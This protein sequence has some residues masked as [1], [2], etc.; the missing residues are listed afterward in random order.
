MALKLQHIKLP[1]S[2]LAQ[3]FILDH[4]QYKSLLDHLQE[5]HED[6]FEDQDIMLENRNVGSSWLHA[7]DGT[8]EINFIGHSAPGSQPL[9]DAYQ[10]ALS[11]SRAVA[12]K[13]KFRALK[14]IKSYAFDIQPDK[15]MIPKDAGV[16]HLWAR[17]LHSHFELIA[18]K[19]LFRSPAWNSH[20]RNRVFT[21]V[22]FELFRIPYQTDTLPLTEIRE[23]KW[24]D[25]VTINRSILQHPEWRVWEANWID[26][27]RGVTGLQGIVRA[28][29]SIMCPGCGKIRAVSR[30]V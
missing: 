5:H 21:Q 11:L 17:E 20:K 1:W 18:V 8:F 4:G 3:A 26:R 19:A 28:Y 30:W 10:D 14:D 9:K 27:L 24:E 7:E 6:L 22:H 23:T 13:G 16:L 29:D 2:Q 15:S 12:E 25:A